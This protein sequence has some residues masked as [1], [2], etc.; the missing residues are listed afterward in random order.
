MIVKIR[1]K[2]EDFFGISAKP[3]YVS[4]RFEL[5]YK[6]RPKKPLRTIATCSDFDRRSGKNEYVNFHRKLV[7]SEK[8]KYFCQSFD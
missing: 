6:V 3:S 1:C 5:W 7:R 8:A 2:Y 4:L